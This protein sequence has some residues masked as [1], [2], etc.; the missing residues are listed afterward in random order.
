MES[1]GLGGM[2]GE[3]RFSGI[4]GYGWS[5]ALGYVSADGKNGS[6]FYAN[7]NFGVGYDVGPS[8][9]LFSV[10]RPAGHDLKIGDFAERGMSYSGSAFFFN[11]SYGRTDQNQRFGIK[12]MVPSN[13][14]TGPV[15][16]T[17]SS[18]GIN[19]FGFGGSYQYGGTQLFWTTPP[20]KK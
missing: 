15:G 14:G 3:I 6:S 4:I 9:S 5:G 2:G 1:T 7:I 19:P 11:S 16:Y 10:N 20:A 17:T 12:D 13:F 18:L 8:F